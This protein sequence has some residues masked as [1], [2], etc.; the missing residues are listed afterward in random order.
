[1]NKQRNNYNL[2]DLYKVLRKLDMDILSKFGDVNISDEDYFLLGIRSDITYNSVVLLIN[3]FS[4]NIGSPGVDSCCRAILEALVILK[5]NELGKISLSQKRIYRYLYTYVDYDNY[6]KQLNENKELINDE[7][8]ELFRQ[9][10]EKAKEV[11]CE[12][13]NCKEKDIKKAFVDDPCFYLKTNLNDDIRFS[14]LIKLYSICKKDTYLYD[15]FSVFLHPR[16][17]MDI[18]FENKVNEE[19]EKHIGTVLDLIYEYLQ[20]SNLYNIDKETNSFEQDIEREELVPNFL[21]LVGFNSLMRSVKEKICKLPDGFDFFTNQFLGQLISII[22]DNLITLSLGY[23]EH[24]ISNFK[25]FIE[26]YSVADQIYFTESKETFDIL[27]NAYL[28]NSRLQLESFLKE[29]IG[30]D[31]ILKEEMERLYKIYYKEKYKLDDYNAFYKQMKRNS[32]YFLSSS[33]KS[34]NAI[35]RSFVNNSPFEEQD[36]TEIFTLYKTSKDMSHA[37]GYN[38]NASQGMLYFNPGKVIYFTFTLLADFISITSKTLIKHEIKI[39]TRK[40]IKALVQL[41]DSYVKTTQE[42]GFGLINAHN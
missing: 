29:I 28:Y 8:L 2:D 30:K 11:I 31:E 3:L 18:N 9:D 19:K 26:Y 17:E 40:E 27:K 42:I 20:K 5:M 21:N 15:F 6:K 32:L 35:V 25:I 12:Y 14:K 23:V 33:E 34:Y 36:K 38:F 37:S 7:R 22:N 24:I 10:K 16:C 1:M 39:D 4:N 41:R 13:F